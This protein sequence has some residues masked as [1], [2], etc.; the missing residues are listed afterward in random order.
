MITI[1][2][3]NQVEEYFSDLFKKINMVEINVRNQ[4]RFDPEQISDIVG[5]IRKQNNNLKQTMI[6]NIRSNYIYRNFPDVNDMLD[7]MA[8][9]IEENARN[10]V[11]YQKIVG[12]F[13]SEEYFSSNSAKKEI[14]Y[15]IRKLLINEDQ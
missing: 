14:A 6:S 10:P 15:Q 12:F 11:F 2:N 13:D 1:T 9:L 3:I 7:E 8:D 5:Y 4:N